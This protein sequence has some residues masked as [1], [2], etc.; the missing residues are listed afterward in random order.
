MFEVSKG[1]AFERAELD[2]HISERK[3]RITRNHSE[4][5]VV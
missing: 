4:A 1:F 2:E 5:M 3:A